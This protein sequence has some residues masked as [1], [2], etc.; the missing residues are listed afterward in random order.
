MKEDKITE[1]FKDAFI[2]LSKS[3]INPKKKKENEY[4]L[5]ITFSEDDILKFEEEQNLEQFL[6]DASDEIS[7]R[8][9]F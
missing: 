4:D 7:K 1:Y 8:L 5:G 9:S 6:N 2:S 3:L